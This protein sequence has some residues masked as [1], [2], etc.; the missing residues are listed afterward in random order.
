MLIARSS[1][2]WMPGGEV[3]PITEDNRH[4]ALEINDRM[5]AAGERI[6]VV[7]RRDFDPQTFDP[8]G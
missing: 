8:K 5:A 1:S 7:A 4:F 6:M 3:L 2:Y